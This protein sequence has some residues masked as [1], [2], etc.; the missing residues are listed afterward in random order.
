MS[1][2]ILFILTGLYMIYGVV[3]VVRNKALNPMTKCAWIIFVIALPVLGTAG[4]LR[5]NFKERHGEW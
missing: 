2:V 5:T 4:Y 1:Y 3:Q